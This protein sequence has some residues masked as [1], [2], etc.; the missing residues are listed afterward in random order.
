[1]FVNSITSSAGVLAGTVDIANR[2]W[3]CYDVLVVHQLENPVKLT[4]VVRVLESQTNLIIYGNR[5]IGGSTK[6]SLIISGT[7][8]FEMEI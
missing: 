6:P 4:L 8:D 2:C 3:T 1:M 7:A 5:G